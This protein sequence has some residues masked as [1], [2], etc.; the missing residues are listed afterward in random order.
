M[1]EFGRLRVLCDIN[2]DMGR[3]MGVVPRRHYRERGGLVAIG[4]DVVEFPLPANSGPAKSE[5]AY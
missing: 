5:V 2:L 4:D 1:A 3:L